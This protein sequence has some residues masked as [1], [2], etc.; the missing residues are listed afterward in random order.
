MEKTEKAGDCWLWTAALFSSGYAAFRLGPKQLRGHRW[1]YE[2]FIGPIPEGAVVMHTCDIKRCVNP[3]HLRVGT[4]AENQQDMIA[5]RR[6]GSRSG[7]RHHAVLRPQKLSQALADEIRERY[8]HGGITQ[9]DL[10]DEYNVN[11]TMISAIVRGTRW[12]PARYVIQ[13]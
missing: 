5:K 7:T 11:Q 6:L 13:R 12:N 10:A 2:H 9:K 1:A 3:A 4:Q 8:T